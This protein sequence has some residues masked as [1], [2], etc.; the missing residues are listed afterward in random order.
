MQATV[1]TAKAITGSDS[2]GFA[3]SYINPD[4]DGNQNSAV[5]TILNGTNGT[6]YAANLNTTLRDQD[7]LDPTNSALPVELTQVRNSFFLVPGTVQVP[8]L[9]PSPTIPGAPTVETPGA[10]ALMTSTR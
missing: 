7:L 5:V 9:T 6:L 2:S 4:A 1:R 10:G 8:T 3:V